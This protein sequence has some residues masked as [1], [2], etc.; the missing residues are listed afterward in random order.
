M[1]SSMLINFSIII[2]QTSG[3]TIVA[4]KLN[5]YRFISHFQCVH[6]GS[7]FTEL[8]TT[9]VRKLLPESWG[10]YLF[11]LFILNYKNQFTR[12]NIKNF[13][14]KDSFVRSTHQMVLLADYLIIFHML[15]G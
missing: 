10:I 4:E 15:V 12:L 13:F 11:Y 3:Y 7:F 8:K 9:T 2:F 1:N 14:L 6:R 5:F